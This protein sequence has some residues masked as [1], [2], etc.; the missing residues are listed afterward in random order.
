MLLCSLPHFYVLT[1]LIRFRMQTYYIECMDCSVSVCECVCYTMHQ[2]KSSIPNMTMLLVV[3]VVLSLNV[4]S[5]DGGGTIP[6]RSQNISCTRELYTGGC[7]D[8]TVSWPR[9]N[10]QH[11]SYSYI[12]VISLLCCGVQASKQLHPLSYIL[13][14]NYNTQ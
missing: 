9:G 1:M 12:T 14:I 10:N 7:A 2:S 8:T 6:G 4:Y 13:P 3:I 11:V 5:T